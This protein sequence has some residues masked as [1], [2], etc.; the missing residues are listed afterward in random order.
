MARP[1]RADVQEP[2]HGRDERE[3]DQVAHPGDGIGDGGR[4]AAGGPNPSALPEITLEDLDADV[5]ICGEGEDA[6]LEWVKEAQGAIPAKK[7]IYGRGRD[8]IDTYPFP[9]RDL[10]DLNGY[11]KRLLGQ[12]SVS[13]I[14]SRG[15]PH[16]C[17]H[18]NS[19]VMGGGS[20][21]ARYRSPGNVAAEIAAVKEAGYSHIRFSDDN[22]CARP[23]LKDLLAAI[24]DCRIA[25]RVFARVD[26]LSEEACSLL[27]KAGCMH[28]AAGFE[29]LNPDNLRAIGKARQI[30][31]FSNIAYAKSCGMTA[32]VSFM[33]GLPFDSRE[34]V[35]RYFSE[36]A[37]LPFDEFEVHPLIPFPGTRIAAEADKW[38]YSIRQGDF[39]DYVLVGKERRTT[40]ALDHRNFSAEDV[41]EWRVLAA[42]ILRSAGKVFMKDSEIAR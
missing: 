28:V 38:G 33:V 11:S 34:S 4:V 2:A 32:R 40:F 6:L 20:L 42:G 29:S 27:S 8:D 37:R 26:D 23:D 39:R 22:F 17:L 3:R 24:A 25:F 30:G 10:V 21:K 7:I 5:V 16:R 1:P 36:A 19:N 12:P 18:C 41:E 15:C 9:A 35:E 13:M 31:K 14:T